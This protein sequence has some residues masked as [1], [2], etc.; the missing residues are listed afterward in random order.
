M[1]KKITFIEVFIVIIL[2]V[3]VVK[4]YDYWNKPGE[5]PEVSKVYTKVPE[6]TPTPTVRIGSLASIA[7]P[8]SLPKGAIEDNDLL[9][10][11]NLATVMAVAE[12]QGETEEEK[13]GNKIF[14]I[15]K[16]RNLIFTDY[17]MVLMPIIPDTF[18]SKS[19]V[20]KPLTNDEVKLEEFNK[21]AEKD[22]IKLEE[23]KIVIE[24]LAVPGGYEEVQE[25]I[26]TSYDKLME[27]IKMGI[28]KAEAKDSDGIIASCDVV[29]EA[30]RCMDKAMQGLEEKGYKPSEKFSQALE[31]ALKFPT[32]PPGIN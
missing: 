32:L 25:N 26:L 21:T 30:T 24:E 2:I 7:V 11:W 12:E 28:E 23:I 27:G 8:F 29:D 20:Y 10:E 19:T 3:V 17:G 16:I 18:N 14:I 13:Y 31:E 22:I 9:P 6:V 1:K 15:S 5:I 4:G